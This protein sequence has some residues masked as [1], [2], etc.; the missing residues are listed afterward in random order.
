MT[1]AEI[2]V[3]VGFPAGLT[4]PDGTDV[5]ENASLQHYGTSTIPSRPFLI[6]SITE[7]KNQ[8]KQ[9]AKVMLQKIL[10]GNPEQAGAVLGMELVADVQR[11]VRSGYYRGVKPN[12]PKTIALKGS[13]NPLIDT[14]TMINSLTFS[15]TVKNELKLW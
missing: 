6:D 3:R 4:E 5:A 9:A 14:G 11:L 10:E 1:A 2:E 12:S 13:D 8:V 7:N 15:V